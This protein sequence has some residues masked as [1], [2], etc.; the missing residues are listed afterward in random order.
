MAAKRRAKAERPEALLSPILIEASAWQRLA[1]IVYADTFERAKSGC[2]K[3]QDYLGTGGGGAAREGPQARL[4][5]AAEHLLFLDSL[6]GGGS[7][8]LDRKG[9]RLSERFILRAVVLGRAGAVTICRA[10]DRPV[11][12]SRSGLIRRSVFGSLGRI[13]DG[14]ALGSVED[15]HDLSDKSD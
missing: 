7:V 4:L 1:A 11:T 2:L 13:C 3:G 10:V 14:A 9:A 15:L 6:I 5:N 12:R 8:V